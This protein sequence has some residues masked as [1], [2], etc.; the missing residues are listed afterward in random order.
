MRTLLIAL[1]MLP[2]S[3]AQA[4][5]IYYD[6]TFDINSLHGAAPADWGAV[7][8]GTSLQL[9][10]T[11]DSDLAVP[12]TGT[13]WSH[14][15]LAS[16]EMTVGD[17][18]IFGAPTLFT[19]RT[20]GSTSVFLEDL[21]PRVC[22]PPD[23]CAGGFGD[24]FVDDVFFGFQCANWSSEPG[25]LE[26]L[27]CASGLTG[28]TSFE[29]FHT[30]QQPQDFGISASLSGITRREVPEPGAVALVVVGLAGMWFARRKPVARRSEA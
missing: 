20:A 29:L 11:W 10:F 15:P 21:Q 14:G 8:L 22:T 17:A 26:N 27:S 25:L 7:S 19:H 13:T 23:P 6:A 5:P 12:E 9:H 16:Y 18:T 24:W 4:A 1:V 2:L 30:S 3:A 28:S